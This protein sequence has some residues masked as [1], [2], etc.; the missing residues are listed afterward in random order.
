[1]TSDLVVA[2]LTLNEE[3]RLPRLIES[4]PNF[5]DLLILDSGSTDQTLKVASETWER[6]NRDPKQIQ[7]YQIEWKGFVAARNK[8]LSLSTKPWILWMDADE[9]ISPEMKQTLERLKIDE[10]DPNIIY[11][12]PRLSYFL[13]R[14]IYHGGW[15]PDL[16]ERLAFREKVL[17]TEGPHGAAVHEQLILK[18]KSPI[19]RRELA[20]QILHRPFLDRQEQR[21]TNLR[22]SALLADGIA[23]RILA[24]ELRRP[25]KF[26]IWIKPIIKF[27]ENYL[28]KGGF[29]DGRSGFWIALGSAQSMHWRMKKVFALLDID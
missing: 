22:Y 9:W 28:F 25:P 13:D 27:F 29:L 11:R 12:F 18:D 6:L 3:R 19:C 15:Y 10:L 5:V 7:I 17:W 16:K 4:L 1:M 21:E 24:G 8:T 14:P 2:V 26:F 20:G 23:R